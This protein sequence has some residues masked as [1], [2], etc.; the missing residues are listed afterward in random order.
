MKRLE[1]KTE[2]LRHEKWAK[3]MWGSDGSGGPLFD[4]PFC[5]TSSEGIN[6]SDT[7]LPP[8]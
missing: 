7:I 8:L 3:K 1:Q 2:H 5:Y 6:P 4:F